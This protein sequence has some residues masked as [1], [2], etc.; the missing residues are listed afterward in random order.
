MTTTNL[1]TYNAKVTSVEQVYFTPVAVVP[2]YYTVPLSSLYCFLS[3]VDPWDDDNNPPVPTQDQKY[4]KQV[5][6][7]M[8]VAKQ[9]QSNELSPV[10]RRVNW[11]S[12]IT[13]DYYRDDVDMFQTDING[14]YVLNFYVKNRYDQ[15]FKCLWNNNGSPSTLEP[16]FEPGS[17]GT[18]NIYQSNDGYKWK[19][20]YTIDLGSKVKFMD[21]NWMPVPVGANTPNPLVSSAGAGS[22][23]VI[24]VTNGGSGYDLAN[25]VVTVT[26]TG[27]GLGATGTVNVANGS[28]SD[29]IVTNPGTNYTKANVSITST[30]GSGAI[31]IAP[32]S[33]IGGH[34]FDAASELGI[35]H[36]MFSIEFDGSEKGN[37][38]TDITYHQLGIVINPTTL[39]DNPSPANGSM[40]KTTTDL[41]VAP[42]FGTYVNDEIVYQ[43]DKNGNVTFTG[44][45]LS[46]D[47]A[48]NVIRLINTTGTLT[49]N[50]SIYGKV[51]LTTRTLLTYS[52]PNFQIFSGYL[53]YI[54]NRSG[55]TRSADGIEQFKLVLGY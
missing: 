4:L 2:P 37:I 3:K 6:K 34:G 25:A 21:T 40:Y 31:A 18:N 14:N 38:P 51:S 28:I 49:T 33:P 50:A 10:V 16:Y 46:F 5:F 39:N 12:G 27:D 54:E 20:I 32:T 35:S 36:I 8:F 44:T 9:I 13:Y 52:V 42:G 29:I 53:S 1:L 43:T 11:T 22:I 7:N 41:V 30:K 23:D 48:S 47:V 24:N 17:Y 45:I 19:Y 55:I 15:V 26:V